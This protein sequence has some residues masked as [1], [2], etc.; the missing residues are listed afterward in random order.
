MPRPID[1]SKRVLS[2]QSGSA[3][4]EFTLVA[5]MFFMLSLGLAEMG[6][7]VFDYNIV[8]SLAREGVRWAS[9]RGSASG[10]AATDVNIS[11]YVK[12]KASGMNLT[13]TVTWTP[14]NDNSP[15]KTVNVQVLYNF[16]SIAPV[17]LSL[18]TIPLSSTSHM[19]IVQG[20]G[21][22]PGRILACR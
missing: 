21:A 20:A 3:I 12:S 8:S 1:Q 19:V 7:A 13:V 10:H 14:A 15:G 2:R 4:V 5:L 22:P 6:R 9:V 18:G 17:L 11:D 16:R